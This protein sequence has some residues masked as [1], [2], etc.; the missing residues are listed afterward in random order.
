MA[1]PIRRNRPSKTYF[2]R[3]MRAGDG[4]GRPLAEWAYATPR[5]PDG[6]A[7]SEL[8]E[9]SESIQRETALVWFTSNLESFQLG[10]GPWFGFAETGLPL[11]APGG[12]PIGSVP[13]GGFGQGPFAPSPLPA[14]A[15]LRQQFEGDLPEALI[16]ALGTA[17]G[18]DWMWIEPGATA[19]PSEDDAPSKADL[20]ADLDAVEEIIRSLVPQH[21]EIGHNGPEGTGPL[22]ASEQAV[23]LD[24]ICRIRAG[25]AADPTQADE[26][27]AGTLQL[28]GTWNRLGIYVLKQA[29]AF[30][31]EANKAVAQKVPHLMGVT[32][33]GW[34]RIAHLLE[35]LWALVHRLPG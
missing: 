17:L 15:V 9:V 22:T 10:S 1:E 7:V 26:V 35:G 24:A 28:S 25:I 13:I 8:R 20:Q 19:Q 31:T 33:L 23:A 11:S 30:I 29:D 14:H 21:G 32:I 34:E 4:V 2:W 3:Q 16:Q 5:Y 12:G 18:D 6:L 27:K